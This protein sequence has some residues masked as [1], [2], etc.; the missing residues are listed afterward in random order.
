MDTAHKNIKLKEHNIFFPKLVAFSVIWDIKLF[1]CA[2]E[3][4]V[5]PW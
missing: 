3:S 2:I 4:E 5:A 1:F